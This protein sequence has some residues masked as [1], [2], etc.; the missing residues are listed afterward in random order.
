MRLTLFLAVLCAS[1][2]SAMP[3]SGTRDAEVRD[4]GLAGEVYEGAPP[5]DRDA[6][7]DASPDGATRADGP[8]RREGSAV[9]ANGDAVFLVDEDHSALYTV[10]LDADGHLGKNPDRSD[11][12]SIALPGRPANLVL[13]GDRVIVT[14]R[15][16]G[17]LLYLLLPTFQPVARALSPATPTSPLPSR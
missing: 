11:P 1:C 4:D 2:Q 15:D 10:A 12:P 8:P 17:L 5:T 6:A 9:A 16:P 14:I 13:S 3:V 7:T